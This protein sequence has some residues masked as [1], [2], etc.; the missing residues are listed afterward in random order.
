[1]RVSTRTALLAAVLVSTSL[2]LISASAIMS[3][4]GIREEPT[5]KTFG[6]WGVDLTSRD[7]RTKAG[8]DFFA[9]ANGSWLAKT[10]IPSDQA[11]TSTGR[12][13]FN[14]TQ[15]QLRELIEASAAKPATPTAAQIGGLYKSFMD[16]AGVE[17]LDAKPLAS[18]LAAVQAVS[19]KPDFVRL[20]GKTASNFGS[21]V[22][23]LG[24][25]ADAKKPMS[26]LYLGQ[27]GLGMPDRDYYLTD[28]FKDKKDAYQAYI[29]RTFTLIKDAAPDEKARAVLAFETEIAKASWAAAE[30]R[31]IDKLYNPMTVDALQKF[32]P[33]IEW[34][35]YL[36]AA[37]LSG[38]QA[39]VVTETTAVQKI[40]QIVA[41]TPLDTLKA[42][43]TFHLVD[44]ASPYL[45]KRFVDSQFEFAGK[46]LSGTPA[47]RPRWKRGVSLIDERLGEAVGK[48]YVAKYF[49]P[50][51]KVKM[52][53][54]VA[55]LKMA[56]AARIR[57][58]TWMSA[59]TKAQALEKLAKMGV[60]VGYPTKWR[61]YSKLKI[62]P[63]DLYGNLARS[64]V[65]ETAYQFNKIGKAVDKAEWGMTPQTV[66]AY[67]GGL[68]N[69]IVFPAGILQPPFFN[70]DADPAV[71]YGAIGA[72]IGHEITHGFDDQGRKIDATGA[73]RDW[74]TP[75]DAKRFVAESEK[76]AG[77]YDTY[78]GVPGA[79]INGKLTLGE[80]IADLGGLLVAIDAYHAS[81]GGKPAPVIDGLTG[82][83]RLFLG[84]AQSW[85]GKTRDD[86]LR[87]QMASDPHSPRKFRVVGATRNVDSWYQSFDVTA[88]DKYFLKPEDRARVW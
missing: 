40:A 41:D 9:H 51:S 45:S 6:A 21:S 82:D 23:G 4:S 55:N 56:M 36:D 62:D 16:E 24:V 43:E 60:M 46:A 20:M 50:A 48:E 61:D 33:A 47:Q 57:N 26:T 72:V 71:N 14:L 30:R 39:V 32:A 70:P 54:L 22:F 1:M 86:A 63:A 69:K 12:D 37:G 68:E 84:Y 17:A 11:S 25:Y 42:W 78:E 34:R 52:D 53:L 5:G 73:L 29:A 49:P 8:D 87:A 75:E 7:L 59:P 65:F 27:A 74:W 19:S 10:E 77:Q 58:S 15:D 76:L 79:R 67:N 31:D 88:N 28:G 83:Q 44:G 13:V 64:I 2:A 35:A 66:D 81:L 80:N 38:L 18:E 85:R 3:A